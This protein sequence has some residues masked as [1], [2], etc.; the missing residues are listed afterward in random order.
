MHIIMCI[1]GMGTLEGDW[2]VN[3]IVLPSPLPH[4]LP[5]PFTIVLI[6][7]LISSIG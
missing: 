1:L 5:F 3:K 4:T 6:P 7:I 2:E